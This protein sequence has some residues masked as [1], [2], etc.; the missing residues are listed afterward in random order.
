MNSTQDI[1]ERFVAAAGDLTQTLGL[2]RNIGQIYAHIYLSPNPQSLDDLTASLEVS[3]GSAS[4]SV[5]QLEQ[6]GALKKI[7]VKGSRKDFYEAGIEFGRIIRRAMIDMVGRTAE[8]ADGLLDESEVWLKQ[9]QNG[10]PNP[11][12]AFLNDRFKH[13]REFHSRAQGLWNSPVIRRLLK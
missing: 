1:R 7:W 10:K 13:L 4:M 12:L 2:G 11:D 3:K 8:S 6:W 5:R 9:R